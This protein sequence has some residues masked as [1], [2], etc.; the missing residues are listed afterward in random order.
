MEP[1]SLIFTSIL[2]ASVP[3]LAYIVAVFAIR[4]AELRT[5]VLGIIDL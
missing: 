3:T 4:G 2:L 5:W 1:L